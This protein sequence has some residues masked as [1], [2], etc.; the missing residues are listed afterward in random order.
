SLGGYASAPE[1]LRFFLT[2]EYAWNGV[3]GRIAHDPEIVRAFVE[4]NG[5]LLDVSAREALADPARAAAMLATPPPPVA[6]LLARLSRARAARDIRARLLLVHGV[7]DHAVPYTESLRMAAARPEGTR[8]VLVHL[9][10]HVEPERG[11]SWL[12]A[13]RELTSLVLVVYGL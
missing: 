1:L 4:A 12:T 13:A 5:D 8:V 10:E 9:L 3:R 2:G 6:D 7:D 11:R